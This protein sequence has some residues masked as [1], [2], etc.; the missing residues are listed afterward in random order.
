MFVVSDLHM[1]DRSPKDNLRQGNRETMFDQ[2]LAYVADQRGQLVLLGDV[3]ELLRYPLDNIVARRRDLL[4]R[5][6]RMDTVYVPGNHDQDLA[7]FIGA[8][9][10][11]HPFFE[12]TSPAF[13]HQVGDTRFKFMHGHEVDPLI[14]CGTRSISRMVGAVAYLLEFR[15]GTC[16][17]S[18]DVFTDVLLEIGEHAL[19]LWNRLTRRMNRALR[20]CYNRMPA[21]PMTRLSRHVRTC[22]MLERYGEDRT[23]DLY[24]VA[25]VGHTHRAGTFEDWYFNSGSW[26]GSHRNFLRISPD[27]NVAVFDWSAAGPQPNH[28]RVAG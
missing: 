26:T 19:E 9:D 8:G 24:D 18:N 28:T 15:Q 14:T 16:I 27:G 3:F 23:K 22:R 2:F 1:G 6:A 17:L 20:H 11:P 21:E 25:I 7:S 13:V 5:L 4:D 10:L 12:R